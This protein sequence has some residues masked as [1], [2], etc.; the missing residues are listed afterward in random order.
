MRTVIDPRRCKLWLG[1]FA[2][3]ALVANPLFA[4][5]AQ[6]GLIRMADAEVSDE[7]ARAHFKA[8]TSLY[9]SGRFK[10]AA[11]EWNEA[12]ALSR[13]EAL[14]YNI[15]VAHRDA[16]DWPGAGDALRRYLATTHPDAKLRLNLEARLRAIDSALEAKAAEQPGPLPDSDAT[17]MPPAEVEPAPARPAELTPRASASSARAG[18]SPLP[19]VL[20]AT[21]AAFFAGGA[22]TGVI[23]NGKVSDLEQACPKDVCPRD[24]DLD[25]KRKSAS[26]MALV[27]DVLFGTGIVVAAFGAVLW[28]TSGESGE[29]R[30]TAATAANFTPTLACGSTGCAAQVRGEF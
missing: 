8:G 12:Y 20:L 10:E 28:L 19:I 11:E 6:P 23:T 5:D 26:S 15:Y 14:L 21:S 16:S 27:T 22:V 7:R 25:A 3:L 29:S 17:A 13:R 1:V 30:A 24:F 4:Q 2:Q 9:E 18:V